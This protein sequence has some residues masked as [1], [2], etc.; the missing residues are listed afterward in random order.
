MTQT[1]RILTIL[2]DQEWHR[3]DR[4]QAE[5]RI[6]RA[7]ARIWDLKRQGYL[8][9]ERRG[10]YGFK[11]YRLIIPVVPKEEPNISIEPLESLAQG[12]LNI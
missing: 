11:E 1:T 6:T 9:D 12:K 3:T 7:P 10:Q 5:A 2:S 8:I 4:L